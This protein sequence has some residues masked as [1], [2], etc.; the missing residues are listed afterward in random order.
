MIESRIT[1]VGTG[2]R[3]LPRHPNKHINDASCCVGVPNPESETSLAQPN[4]MTI[5]RNGATLYVAALGS[6]KIGIQDETRLFVLTQFDHS[7][8]VSTP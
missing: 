4:A 8:T 2:S 7:I 6:S 1:V 3:V 5:T